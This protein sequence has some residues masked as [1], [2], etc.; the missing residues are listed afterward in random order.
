MHVLCHL[1]I[2][3]RASVLFFRLT[4]T[5]L[6][7]Q[8]LLR[9]PLLNLKNTI[10]S[11]RSFFIQYLTPP[12]P[13]KVSRTEYRFRCCFYWHKPKLIP[14][15]YRS[16]TL[17]FLLYNI[18]QNLHTVAHTLHASLTHLSITPALKLGYQNNLSALCRHF[19]FDRQLFQE[20]F[21]SYTCM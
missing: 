8:R 18:F 5:L 19:F 14:L 10:H 1:D 4:S 3:P 12:P 16:L 7:L 15:R 11:F 20:N 13:H 17:Y 21:K 9:N 2:H 6:Y